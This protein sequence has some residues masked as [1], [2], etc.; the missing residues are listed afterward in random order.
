M[1]GVVINTLNTHLWELQHLVHHHQ[2]GGAAGIQAGHHHQEGGAAGVQAG[3]HHQ[4]E[5][6]AGVEAGYQEVILARYLLV[7]EK[8]S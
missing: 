4:E 3:H 5:G 1:L 2:E 8:F 6:A 7:T